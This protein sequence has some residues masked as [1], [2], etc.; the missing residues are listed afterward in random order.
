MV[1]KQK[2][3]TRRFEAYKVLSICGLV[4]DEKEGSSHLSPIKRACFLLRLT[5][6]SSALGQLAACKVS[7]IC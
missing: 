4:M 3:K 6:F 7:P 1:K 5:F 2:M